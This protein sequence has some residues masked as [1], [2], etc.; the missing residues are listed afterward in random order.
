MLNGFCRW[1]QNNYIKYNLSME[2]NLKLNKEEALVLFE[3]FARINEDE[4]ENLFSN[5]AE[6]KVLEIIEC[7]L[8]KELEDIFLEN[9]KIILENAYKKINEA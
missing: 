9:Y 2:I 6:Q 5:N 8:E 7:K 3:F 1:L 4:Y